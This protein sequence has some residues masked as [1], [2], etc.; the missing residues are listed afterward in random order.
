MAPQPPSYPPKTPPPPKR[1]VEPPRPRPEGFQSYGPPGPLTAATPRSRAAGAMANRQASAWVLDAQP[2]AASSAPR[3]AEDYVME[4]LRKWG[5]RPAADRIG[6]LMDLLVAET[7]AD[8]GSRISVQL[9]VDDGTALILVMSHQDRPAATGNDDA[10]DFLRRVG[11]VG[12]I[13]SCG[14]DAG[15]EGSG[16][17]RW[18]VIDLTPDPDLTSPASAAV[19]GS[20]PSR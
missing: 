19:T 16:L 13:V 17:G 15:R 2:W 10:S 4:A 6:A 7:L 3:K 18:A 9:A 5:H 12:G 14:M 1:P 20:P 11:A 8:G